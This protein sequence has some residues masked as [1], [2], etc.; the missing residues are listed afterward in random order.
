M[1]PLAL[2]RS[3]LDPWVD[4]ILNA[5]VAG[6][7]KDI[8]VQLKTRPTFQEQYGKKYTVQD[9]SRPSSCVTIRIYSYTVN[10]YGRNI[11]KESRCI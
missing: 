8:L 6:P 2:P 7:L 1:S 3:I 4:E 11:I 5:G 10:N 9:C